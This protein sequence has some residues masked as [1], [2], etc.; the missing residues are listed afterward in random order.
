[1]KIRVR[2]NQMEEV[3]GLHNV[4]P[5]A[6]HHVDLMRTEVPWHWHEAL[7]FNYVV[8]GTVK[9]STPGQTLVLQQ[10]QGFFINSNR[11]A[12][13]AAEEEGVLDSHLFHPVFLSGHFKSV[14]ETKYLNP[15]I[16]NK[17]LEILDIRGETP[18]QRKLLQKL[19]ELSALQQQEDVEFQSR[20]LL[21]EIWLLLMEDLQDRDIGRGA[22]Q[23]H[24]DRI[25]TMMAYIQENY[26][27]HLTLEQIAQS[28]AISTR[29]CLRCFRE[30]IRQT[31]MEYLIEYRITMAKKL[32]ENSRLP[33]TEVALRTGFNSSAY[34]SKMFRRICGV[35]PNAYRRQW[36][37]LSDT[38]TEE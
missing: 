4:Y 33:I 22:G 12:T 34:F 14:F 13:M 26:Q 15:V 27:E 9:V 5:Y 38:Q 32:L 23:K 7:E 35:T 25:L 29:E 10:N 11:L 31:P 2:Q 28:A 16:Q 18:V 24:Q 21:S 19:R 6:F 1:M 37:A 17:G 30:C 3:E 8:R 36:N 20:N